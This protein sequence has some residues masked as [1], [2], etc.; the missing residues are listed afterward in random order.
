MRSPFFLTI[1]FLFLFFSSS[2]QR[3]SAAEYYDLALDQIQREQYDSALSNL[4]RSIV[5][6][7]DPEVY[8]TRGTLYQYM[9]EDMRALN[10]FTSCIDLGRDY[11]EAYFKRGEI[12]LANNIYSKAIADFSFLLSTADDETTQAIFFRIDPRGIDQV[13]VS[14]LVNMRSSVKALRSRAYQAIGEYT[15]ALKD[16][17]EAIQIDSTAQNLVNRALLHTEIGDARAAVQNLNWAIA[18]EPLNE[19][20]WFNLLVLETDTQVPEELMADPSFGPMLSFK[21][22]EAYEKQDYELAEHLFNQAILLDSDDPTLLLNA[23]RLDLRNGN[24]KKARA[25]FVKVLEIDD[26]RLET[27]YLIGNTFFREQKFQES[28]AFYEQFLVRDR[29]NAS[30][31]YNAAMAYFELDKGAEACDCLQNAVDRGMATA[32]TRFRAKCGQNQ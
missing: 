9:G 18:L 10:D 30:V 8:F 31:W 32:A 26:G 4:N 3:S 12:Y 11:S 24:Y 14:T 13:Q 21:A 22:V 28:V 19:V 29:S 27:Y 25:R 23:G 2:A 15:K 17:S 5:I 6:R 7:R 16:I 20:A 1:F